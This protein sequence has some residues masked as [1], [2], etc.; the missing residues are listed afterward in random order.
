MKERILPA[1]ILALALMG[2][3]VLLGGRYSLI[4]DSNNGVVWRLDRYTGIV[5]ICG[6]PDDKEI[7][8]CGDLKEGGKIAVG[9]K[10]PT[11]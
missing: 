7:A 1:I 9:T 10:R 6:A 5:S 4:H 8:S 3:A 11:P 2:S